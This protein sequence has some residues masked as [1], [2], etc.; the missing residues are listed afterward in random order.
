MF[1]TTIIVMLILI[2]VLV[3]TTSYYVSK[4][5]FDDI[6]NEYNSLSKDLNTAIKTV[7]SDVSPVNNAQ[8][9]AQLQIN[10]KNNSDAALPSR[11]DVVPQISISASGHD[12][13]VLQQ[14]SELL[15]DIQ[16]IVRNEVLANRS[17]VPLLHEDQ[18]EN[19]KATGATF[20]GQEY[21]NSSNKDKEYRCPKNPD[22]SCPPI[23]DMTQYI[24]KDSIPCWGCSLDY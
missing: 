18:P 17:T 23:P 2:L 3:I 9:A 20:Q 15:K 24:K 13:A 8:T 4:E 22:G 10:S 14:K 11:T 5:G 1:N 7:A 16:K 6:T 12:A 21:E 19:N